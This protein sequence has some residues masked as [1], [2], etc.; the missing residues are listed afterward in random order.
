MCVG[1]ADAAVA[2]HVQGNGK[3][4]GMLRE[5]MALASLPGGRRGEGRRG[6]G[7]RGERER[8]RVSLLTQK[9]ATTEK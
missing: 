6:Q 5:K 8:E 7:G 3:E 4:V 9:P 1:G 2:G